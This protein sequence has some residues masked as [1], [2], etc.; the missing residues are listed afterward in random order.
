L[1]RSPLAIIALWVFVLAGWS[2]GITRVNVQAQDPFHA[3]I[4]AIP[5]EVRQVTSA[6]RWRT[7]DGN[8]GLYRVIALRVGDEH[9]VDRLYVQWV[10]DDRTAD[11]PQVVATVAVN[12]VN[13]AGPFT[14]TYILNSER[15]TRLRIRVDAH[16]SYTGERTSFVLFATTP[17][18]VTTDARQLSGKSK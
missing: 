11:L 10:R 2:L 7:P 15:L 12:E 8:A 18:S 5:P 16:N 6:G 4:A 14:F 3:G 13:D 17:G 1:A 9:V